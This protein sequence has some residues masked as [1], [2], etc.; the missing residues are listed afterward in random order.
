MGFVKDKLS[1]NQWSADHLERV[2]QE[3]SRAWKYPYAEH[4]QIIKWSDNSS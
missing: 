1:D 2:K 3:N 4:N